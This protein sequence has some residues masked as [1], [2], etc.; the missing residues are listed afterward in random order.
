MSKKFS[1]F[2][3]LYRTY[4]YRFVEDVSELKYITSKVNH[5]D[6]VLDIGAHKGGYL[7]WI[8]KAVGERGKV[9]AFEPQP[10]LFQY[11][12][13]AIEGFRY[14][15]IDLHQ[16]G[17]SSKEGSLELFIPKAQG[18]TSPGATFENRE[19]QIGH[20]FQ[21]PIVQLDQLLARRE[22]PISLIKVDV[23]G[24]ELE[25]FKGA[26]ELLKKDRPNLIFECEK[27]HLNDLMIKDI[28]QH[29][30]NLDYLGYFF[31]NGRKTP[32]KD[33]DPSIHQII[34]SKKDIVNKRTYSNNFVFEPTQ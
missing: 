21:V 33:F 6:F 26:N 13:E 9:I 27:R 18:L 29:L 23:E 32:I 4:K 25:V 1:K 17:V 3:F 24:H 31:Y 14:T 30:Q 7:H 11:L 28:F 22:Q 20:S 15:N 12:T 19:G 10:I 8:R 16:A 34:D 5:G 2:R